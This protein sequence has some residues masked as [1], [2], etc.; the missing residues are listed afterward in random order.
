[1]PKSYK[2]LESQITVMLNYKIYLNL[3]K[4][5]ALF[6]KLLQPKQISFIN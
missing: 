6:E 2:V 4:L 3:C 5:I 1:M